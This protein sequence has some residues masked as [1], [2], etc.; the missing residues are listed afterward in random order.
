VGVRKPRARELWDQIMK[1]TYDHAEP[2]ILFIDRMNQDNNLNYCETIAATNPCAEQPLPAYGCCCLG[3]INLTRFVGRAFS[4]KAA[5]DYE[6]FGKVVEVSVR[7][8]DN[9]LDVTAWPLKAQH[10]EAMAKRRVGLGFTGL[11][12]ALIMLRL[13]LRLGSRTP[14]AAKISGIY[15]RYRLPSFQRVGGRSA[16]PSRSSTP[17][18]I[19]RARASPRACPR[20]SRR[21]SART[22]S[23]TRISS[24]SRPR[25]RSASPLPQCFERIEPPFSWIYTRKKAHGRWDAEGIPGRGPRLA[26]VQA[27]RRGRERA[28]PVLVHSARALGLRARA[29]GRRGRA[30]CRYEHLQDGERAGDLPLRRFPGSLLRGMEV[31]TEGA[32]DLSAEQRHRSVL[33]VGQESRPQDFVGNDRNRRI[34]IKAIPKPVLASLRWP[35]RPKLAG[36]NPAWTY[37]IEHPHGEFA[38][39]VGHVETPERAHPSK[40]GLNGAEQPRGLGPWR[41]RSRWTCARTTRYG[42]A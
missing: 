34:E 30:V 28:A 8:L 36:G 9:V 31:G 2:G 35:G 12:D 3:S 23:A 32:R 21:R 37:M 15:A 5:F 25:A 40:S 4:E 1:S 11:G 6:R 33:S 18:C 14:T 27:R 17:T 10:E 20:S 13:A 41:S 16:A 29:D 22:A 38:I 42:C 7:M 24:R 26:P 39:F 19:S